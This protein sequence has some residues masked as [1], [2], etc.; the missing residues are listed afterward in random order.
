M[1]AI[2]WFLFWAHPPPPSSPA[3]SVRVRYGLDAAPDTALERTSPLRPPG[4]LASVW[5]SVYREM[6]GHR[7]APVIYPANRGTT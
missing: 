4:C 6:P 3:Y 1:T 5:S 2:L 7:I